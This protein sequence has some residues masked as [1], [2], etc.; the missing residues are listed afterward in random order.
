MNRSVNNFIKIFLFVSLYACSPGSGVRDLFITNQDYLWRVVQDGNLKSDSAL[1][2]Y[3]VKKNGYIDEL[4][5]KDSQFVVSKL[6]SD[7]SDFKKW[8]FLNDS[9]MDIFLISY[10][11]RT[12][13]DSIFI[14]VNS[15][16]VTDTLK[17]IKFN[18]NQSAQL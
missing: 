1:L 12:I 5:Y 3:N 18:K 14:G 2:F 4:I 16:Y 10:K 8:R 13:N 11:V 6:H 17:L 7:I 15:K 9:T